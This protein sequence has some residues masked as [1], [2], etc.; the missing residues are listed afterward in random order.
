MK[1][2]SSCT[3]SVPSKAFLIGEYAVLLGLP[4]VIFTFS[5]RFKIVSEIQ[6]EMVLDSWTQGSPVSRLSDWMRERCFPAVTGQFYDPYQ[7]QGGFGASTAQFA[8][9]YQQSAQRSEGLDLSWKA[10][11]KLYQELMKDE[12]LVPSGGDLV[13]QWQGG[14]IAFDPVFG[15]SVEDLGEFFKSFS[16]LVFSATGQ[17]GRKVPTHSHLEA[18]A[19]RKFTDSKLTLKSALLKSVLAQTIQ[20]ALEAIRK[21]DEMI[22]GQAMSQFADILHQEGLEVQSTWEDRQMLGQLPGVLGVKGAGA[23][24]SDAVLVLLRSA[25]FLSTRERVIE[26]AQSRGLTLVANGVTLESGVMCET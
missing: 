22:L 17:P 26:E 18:L 5:P 9:V 23:L 7:S 6:G 19:R 13:A 3:I 10:V 1:T 15:G 21:G 20:K 25:D 16:F 2:L 14:V 4:A 12:P 24:Q 11:L 8:M